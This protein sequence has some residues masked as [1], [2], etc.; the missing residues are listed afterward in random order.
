MSIRGI[1]YAMCNGCGRCYDVCPM[2]VFRCAGGK[3]YIA[4]PLDCM[5]CFLCEMDCRQKAIIMDPWRSRYIPH[6][7]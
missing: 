6:T 4:Y 5:T 2:D 3:V 7:W 1:D